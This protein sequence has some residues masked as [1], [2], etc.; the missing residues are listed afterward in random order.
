MGKR[1]AATLQQ[2]GHEVMVWNRSPGKAAELVAGGAVE[3][4][5]P[6]E[7]VSKCSVTYAMLADPKASRATVFGSGGVLE[8]IKPVRQNKH[9][10]TRQFE[11][12]NTTHTRT[13]THTH[14][15]ALVRHTVSTG[16]P[17]L[18]AHCQAPAPVQCCRRQ[19]GVYL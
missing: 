6:A 16:N 7:V 12:I 9:K 3:A 1:M 15:V 10:R 18:G 14:T 19:T 5:T 11:Q 13:H 8:G 4:S 17:H 2:G